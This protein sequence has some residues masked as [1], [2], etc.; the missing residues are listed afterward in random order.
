MPDV[1]RR[2]PYGTPSL[3]YQDKTMLISFEAAI[4][5]LQVEVHEIAPP[6]SNFRH[7]LSNSSSRPPSGAKVIV[8]PRNMLQSW[9]IFRNLTFLAFQKQK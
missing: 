2:T 4:M 8:C 9:I 7:C 3:R 1:T 5:S 6:R